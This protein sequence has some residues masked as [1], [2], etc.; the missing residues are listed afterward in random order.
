MVH[1][2]NKPNWHV[3]H[4]WII[5][6]LWIVSVSHAEIF[7]QYD[8]SGNLVT[9]S[10]SLAVTLPVFQ[11]LGQTYQG[12]DS[13]GLLSISV[14]VT[15]PGQVT[16]QWLLNGVSISGATN[17]SF[18]L[19][20]TASNNLGNYQLVASNSGGSV[21]SAV[22]NVSFFDPNGTGLPVAWEMQYF[23]HTGVDPDAD[24]DGDCESNYQ[25]YLDGTNP[26]NANSVVVRLHVV[27]SSGGTVTVTPLKPTYQT[28][29][30]I[31]VTA[32]PY[33]HYL[34]EGLSIANCSSANVTNPANP[35]TVAMTGSRT[36]EPIFLSGNIWTNPAGGKWETGGNWALGVQ[37]SLGEYFVFITNANTKTRTI[38]APRRSNAPNSMPIWNLKVSAPAGSTNTLSISNVGV[39]NFFRVLDR[40]PNDF[41]IGSGGV[42]SVTNSTVLL[43]Y[44][45]N[46]VI[47]ALDA[48]SVGAGSQ[49]MRLLIEGGGQLSDVNGG[50]G[51]YP[52]G[53]N[54]TALVTG[55]GSAWRSSG[56][57]VV[58]IGGPHCSLTVS[59]GSAVSCGQGILGYSGSS[60]S[61]TVL[62]SDAGSV[63]SNSTTLVVGLSGGGSEG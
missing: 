21:T 18:F 53:S 15:A 28:N 30:T 14:P 20:N 17:D 49:N 38:D 58:G 10:N 55:S 24:P 29:D 62:V 57:F 27:P 41:I 50:L 5:L 47:D 23:G 8:L 48:L 12:A 6:L 19:A 2:S 32:T 11:Q 33:S 51:Y 45:S 40:I 25:E 61:N 43:D 44:G 60:A 34:Y 46:S 36:I 1:E 4:G 16:Y 42:V 3:N 7:L 31:Q 56:L 26:T 52:T 59:N 35:A 13:N 22:L 63:W 37:P 39:G 9:Q 54:N